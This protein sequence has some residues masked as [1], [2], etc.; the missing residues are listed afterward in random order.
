MSGSLSSSSP[1]PVGIYR[2][3][4]PSAAVR[5]SPLCFGSMNLGTNWAPLLGSVS[6]NQA[7]ELLDH[8]YQQGGNFID[9]ASNYQEGQSEEWIGEWMEERGN[10]DEIVLATK[11]TFPYKNGPNVIKANFH[12]N[13]RKCLKVAV[14]DS[15]KKLQTDY[16]DILYVHAW[17]YTAS[18]EELMPALDHLVK[19]GKVLYLGISDAPAWIVSKANTYARCNGMSPF[20][21][22]QG[23]WSVSFRDLEREILPMC[24]EEKMGLTIYNALG[25]GKFK[26]EEELARLE[27]EEDQGRK[28]ESLWKITP[29]DQKAT[30]VLDKIA[31]ELKSSITS[32]ALAYI[33][34]KAPYVFPV[35]GVRKLDYLKGNIAALN[36]ELTEAHMKELDATVPPA[37]TFPVNPFG[38]HA[39]ENFAFLSTGR[40]AWVEEPSAIPLSKA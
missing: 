32:I 5:V 21:V 23:A 29:D 4:S 8:F 27:K 36:V 3:L 24:K 30:K 38:S 22:Y 33:I 14:Q 7:F 26:T 34:L 25:G 15:L 9:T 17:D 6:K 20:V 31:K 16:I 2:Q 35:I 40:Y 12:G 1:S 19:S 11:F 28:L 37:P 13:S 10:R 39:R 18:V